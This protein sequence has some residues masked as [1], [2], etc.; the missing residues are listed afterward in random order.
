MPKGL[1]IMCAKY[2]ELKYVFKIFTALMVARL[3]ERQNSCYFRC[4]VENT[5]NW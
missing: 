5:R 2:Y 1:Q 3:L 4:P